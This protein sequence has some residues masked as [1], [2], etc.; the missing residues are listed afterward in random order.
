M[1]PKLA[2]AQA[3]APPGPLSKFL[4]EPSILTKTSPESVTQNDLIRLFTHE[5]T[6]L[7][8]Q[9]FYPRED[10]KELGKELGEKARNGEV[11]NWRVVTS[12]RG[13]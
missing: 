8:I 10:A 5:I 6:A 2:A 9:N 11:D 1:L 13:K 4:K 12:D 3:S 7:K